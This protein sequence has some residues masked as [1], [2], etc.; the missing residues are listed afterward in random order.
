MTRLVK[1]QYV[2][3]GG[4]VN[5]EFNA[6]RYL[7]SPKNSIKIIP[8]EAYLNAILSQHVNIKFLRHFTDDAHQAALRRELN[9]GSEPE[10]KPGVPEGQP[11]QTNAARP[12]PDEKEQGKT[13]QS[14]KKARFGRK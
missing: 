8:E 6:K 12:A 11:D 1:L 10:A 5:I 4:H 14:P 9:G 2:G 13:S 7:F 3:N